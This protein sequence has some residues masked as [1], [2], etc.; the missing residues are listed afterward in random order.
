MIGIFLFT[1]FIFLF[2]EKMSDMYSFVKDRTRLI[3]KISLLIPGFHGYKEKELRR[4]ADRLIREYALR[5][6]KVSYDS[7]RNI[8]TPLAVVGDS[9]IFALYNMV[10]AVFDRIMSKL[11][12]ADYGYSGF[13][14][15]VKIREKE[16]DALLNYDYNLVERIPEI[17]KE[18]SNV[19]SVVSSGNK[20]EISKALYSLKSKLEEFE[21]LIIERENVILSVR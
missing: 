11:R 7:F 3:E 10:Q 20:E 5:R 13:F 1:L 9:G 15:A 8:M 16:L 2:E 17:E 19:V 14:D 18:V 21:R 6:L 4:E 12:A